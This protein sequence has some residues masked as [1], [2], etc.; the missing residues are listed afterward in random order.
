MSVAERIEEW[1][2]NWSPAPRESEHHNDLVAQLVNYRNAL[3]DPAAEGAEERIKEDGKETIATLR[4]ARID[5]LGN[6]SIVAMPDDP[7]YNAQAP[8]RILSDTEIKKLV[9]LA[10]AIVASTEQGPSPHYSD[11]HS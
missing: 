2:E 5:N 6:V 3:P 11:P 4:R 10:G 8:P 7:D 9:E 1:Q